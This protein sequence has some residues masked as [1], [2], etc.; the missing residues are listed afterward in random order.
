MST[1]SPPSLLVYGATGY[2]GQ[3]IAEEAVR[4]GLDFAV[5]GRDDMKVHALAQRLG[6]PGRVFSLDNPPVVREELR[7]VRAV[8]N[9][10]GPFSE[11]AERLTDACIAEGVHYLDTTAEFAVYALAERRSAAADVAG[12]DARTGCRL[13]RRTQ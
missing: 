12:G 2:T 11:T 9:V 10:A 1:T 13:G 8:L 4:A 5:A 6:V 7:G 3:L